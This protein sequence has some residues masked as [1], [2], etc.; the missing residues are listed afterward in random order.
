MGMG[1]VIVFMVVNLHLRFIYR[2][3]SDLRFE[4]PREEGKLTLV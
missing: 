3:I 1:T 2:N 4:E